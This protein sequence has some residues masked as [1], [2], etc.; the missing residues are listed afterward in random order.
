MLSF[1]YNNIFF[2]PLYNYLILLVGFLPFNDL[3]VAVILLTLTV[4]I[5]LFPLSHKASVT[6]QKIKKIE[7]EIKK[8]KEKFKNNKEELAK[9]TMEI[10]REHG[11]SPFS[12]ILMLLVQL[13]V[14]IALFMIFKNGSIFD[15]STLY[16][17]VRIPEEINTIFLGFI[18][19]SKT[20][21]VLSFTAALS[22]FFQVRLSLPASQPQTS[23]KDNTFKNQLQKSMGIQMKYIMPVFIFFIARNFVSVL[24]LYWTASNIFAILHELFVKRRLAKIDERRNQ[25]N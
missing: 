13:P 19:L 11:I 10:Y 15:Q 21:Y 5:V 3:G 14:F 4:R 9:K 20:S 17:F 22:Q 8:I 6:Q 23:Q 25:Q 1:L 18:D 16:S 7:P 2:K 24:A 12:G